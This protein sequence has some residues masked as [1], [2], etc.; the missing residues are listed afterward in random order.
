MQHDQTQWQVLC[1]LL[2]IE[3]TQSQ[4]YTV[5]AQKAQL[6]VEDQDTAFLITAYCVIVTIKNE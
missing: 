3:K 1:I 2:C 4:V 5:A 6:I